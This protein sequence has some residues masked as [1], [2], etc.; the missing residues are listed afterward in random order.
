MDLSPSRYDVSELREMAGVQ[1]GGRP[2]ESR[3]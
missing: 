2:G 1:L 3:R